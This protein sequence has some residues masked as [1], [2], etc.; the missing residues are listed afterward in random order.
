L[1]VLIKPHE[2]NQAF[3]LSGVTV[4]LCAFA[5]GGDLLIHNLYH[6]NAFVKMAWH[7]NDIITLFVVVPLMIVAIFLAQKG[8]FRWFLIL[9][10]LLGY[11]FYNFAFY[12]FG[13]AFNSFFLIYTT[14]LTTSAS[15]LIFITIEA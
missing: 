14:L 8:S 4:F 1:A 11:V 5:S 13:A 7:T 6:D 9:L 15:S 10:G 12:L 2:N 3:I